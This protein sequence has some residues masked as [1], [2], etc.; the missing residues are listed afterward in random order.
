MHHW[1]IN[2]DGSPKTHR[3]PR[4][5]EVC[6][7]NPKGGCCL[8]FRATRK[9]RWLK[10]LESKPRFFRGKRHKRFMRSNVLAQGREPALP[11]KRPSGAAGSASQEEE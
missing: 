11:A 1:Y 5:C 7:E 3:R 4:T 9:V 6:R 8:P 2:K 10:A